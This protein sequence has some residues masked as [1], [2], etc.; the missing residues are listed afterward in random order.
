MINWQFYPR[1]HQTPYH[2]DEV[3]NTFKK[4]EK[5]VDSRVHDL[6]SDSV[7]TILK[8]GL[9]GSGFDIEASKKKKDK[10]QVPVLFGRNG[11]V[12]KYFDADGFNYDT[13]TVIEVEAG[14]AVANYQFLK[15][16]F[17]ACV[18]NNAQYLTI[19]VRNI[20]KESS[21][22]EKV[23]NFLDTLYSSNRLQLPLKGILIIGY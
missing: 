1:N 16:F 18:M 3:L 9:E 12:E 20:Y 17:Q 8:P 6:N 23:A 15:D 2:L 13:G 21:D 10:V 7:L 14:R 22:F 11:A 19:A 4:V 5:E